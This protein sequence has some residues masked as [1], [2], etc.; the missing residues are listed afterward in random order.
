M[1]V[2]LNEDQVAYLKEYLNERLMDNLDLDE[3]ELLVDLDDRLTEPEESELEDSEAFT[4]ADMR[5]A[6]DEPKDP[7][8][9]DM[10]EDEIIDITY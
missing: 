8:Q 2:D 4:E 7:N 5:A 6:F 9:L 10:F 1:L 3:A